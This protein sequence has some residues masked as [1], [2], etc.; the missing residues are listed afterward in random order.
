MTNKPYW[1]T[2]IEEEKEQPPPNIN[3]QIQLSTIIAAH[4]NGARSAITEWIR[5]RD[6]YIAIYL[7][8]VTALGGFY[9]KDQNPKITILRVI[10]FLTVLA[11]CA[12]ISADLHI[13]LTLL[14]FDHL[15]IP[16]ELFLLRNWMLK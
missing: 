14:T 16:I 4:Y 5:L 15:Q 8:A 12:Y 2:H 6:Q 1:L 11:V 9:L 13:G 10:P 3:N 7:T